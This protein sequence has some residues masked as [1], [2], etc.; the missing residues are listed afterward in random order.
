MRDFPGGIGYIGA[1]LAS[2]TFEEASR[3]G[4]C[5]QRRQ[6]TVAVETVPVGIHAIVPRPSVFPEICRQLVLV[7]REV[8]TQL[9]SIPKSR[10]TLVAKLIIGVTADLKPRRCE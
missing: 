1:P 8:R 2:A 3:W 7:E 10:I 5:H 6:V 9:A 4:V